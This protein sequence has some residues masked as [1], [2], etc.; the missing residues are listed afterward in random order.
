MIHSA[1]LITFDTG[2]TIVSDF[3]NDKDYLINEINNLEDTGSTNYYQPLVNV[4]NILKDYVK[5]DNKEVIV[6]FLTDGY[7]NVDT[8]KVKCEPVDRDITMKDKMYVR[9]T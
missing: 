4:D 1:A 2:S 8:R 3:T 5:S 6:L 9:I 7:P